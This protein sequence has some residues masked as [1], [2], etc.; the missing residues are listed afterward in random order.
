MEFDQ[1]AIASGITDSVLEYLEKIPGR[2]FKRLLSSRLPRNTGYIG[3]VLAINT[4]H[5]SK[6]NRNLLGPIKKK[7]EEYLDGRVFNV[8]VLPKKFATTIRD[9]DSA[10]L[11]LEKIGGHLIIYGVHGIDKERGED[12]HSL[13]LDGLVRHERIPRH[14]SR[15]FGED[16]RRVLP[17]LDFFPVGDELS[18]FA[19]ETDHLT[20]VVRLIVGVALL[21]SGR[22]SESVRILRDCHSETN[23]KSYGS[24]EKDEVLRSI[25]SH[26]Y[27]FALNAW[28]DMYHQR[29]VI[30]R[31]RQDILGSADVVEELREL[32][33]DSYSAKL[34]AAMIM[35]FEGNSLKAISLL[36]GIENSDGTWRYSLG[37]LHSV[38]GNISYALKHYQ[39]AM[40]LN[41][42]PSSALAIDMFLT[43]AINEYP[44]KSQLIYCRAF[45]NH[46]LKRDHVLARSDFV[47]FLGTEGAKK[48]PRL[49]KLSKRYINRIDNP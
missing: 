29:Y 20:I 15:R 2:I 11:V 19:F 8:V 38:V 5:P 14:I 43:D 32:V 23:R 47:E 44:G 18:R 28:I 26:K 25:T 42:K 27:E 4:E 1:K 24:A 31:D 22:I 21:L 13:R 40:N 12:Q 7:L 48:F 37:F 10:R 33:P 6:L 16:F 49:K 45:V 34:M 3:I 35:H 46:K 30:S 9:R 41:V 17:E 36:E 39:K